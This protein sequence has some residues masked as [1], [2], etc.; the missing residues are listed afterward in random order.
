M[1]QEQ[2]SQPILTSDWGADEELLLVSGLI[3]NGLGNWAEVAQ[4]IGT[5]TKGECEKH[6][7][8]V[9]L[10]AAGKG[11]DE[12]YERDNDMEIDGEGSLAGRKRRREFMPVRF[13]TVVFICPSDP[14]AHS[15]W[16]AL[17]ISIPMISRR[18]NELA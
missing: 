7:V 9:Y 5:R 15:P 17:S 11:S 4:H 1:K 14:L 16:I 8:E 12:G 18:R 13:L 6:Y 3:I 2:H 10:G